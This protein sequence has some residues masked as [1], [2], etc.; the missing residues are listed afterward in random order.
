MFEISAM[1]SQ[2]HEG[3][4]AMWELLGDLAPKWQSSIVSYELKR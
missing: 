3:M 1:K 4:A 2:R